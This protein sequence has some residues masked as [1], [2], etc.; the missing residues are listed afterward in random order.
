LD[1]VNGV[2]NVTV[3][4]CYFKNNYYAVQIPKGATGWKVTNNVG[5]NQASYTVARSSL[6]LEGGDA[7]ITKN[8]F[9][10]NNWYFDGNKPVRING[11]TALTFAQ[12]QAKGADLHGMSIIPGA[13]VSTPSVV[14]TFTPT[15]VVVSPTSTNTS[16]VPASV[17]PIASV[18]SVSPTPGVTSMPASATPVKTSAPASV[19][20][21]ASRVATLPSPTASR[22]PPSPTPTAS[23]VPVLP[24]ATSVQPT[25]TSQQQSQPSSETKYDDKNGSFVYSSDWRDVAIASASG[26]SFKKTS[27]DGSEV[28]FTFTGQSFSL[29]YTSGPKFGKVS[30]YV[31][32]NLVKTINQNEK[33]TSYQRRWNYPTQL[34]LGKHTIKIVVETPNASI[35]AVI[36]R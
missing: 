28:T 26:G 34:S 7:D 30:I 29:I 27:E 31:D 8:F 5:Y 17:T 33:K 4:H 23:S 32:G 6:Q 19:T 9:D 3:D 18:V 12:W 24:T 21:T 36:V 13:T 25:A 2:N 35:D 16:T 11:S 15:Q 14:P 20:P 22:I 10:Y 1:T